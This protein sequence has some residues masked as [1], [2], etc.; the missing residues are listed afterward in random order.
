M[1]RPLLVA[2]V[3]FAPPCA[4]AWSDIGHGVI[5]TIAYRHLNARAKSRVDVLLCVG[6][7]ARYRNIVMASNWAD[8]VRPQRGETGPWHYKDLFFRADGKPTD[9]KPDAENVVWAIEKFKRQ[10]GNNK[11]TQ[12]ERAE[13]LRWLLHFVGDAHQPLHAESRVTDAL[14]NGDRGG[15]DFSI[16]PGNGLPEWNTNLHRVWDSGCGLFAAPMR[17]GEPGADAVIVRIADQIMK[18][19]PMSSLS[20][21]I[22]DLD[23]DNWIRSG[24]EIS[25]S[26]CY[27]TTEGAVPDKKYVLTG[28]RIS[29]GRT[30]LAA[31]RLAAILNQILG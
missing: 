7:D 29:G 15:N 16:V 4:F 14:P 26:F 31:Y 28:Q 17:A 23:A 27:T 5:G 25:K 13:A 22:K 12:A 2:L 21:Q 8:E 9:L 30:A 18:D 19:R 24:F 11:V 20:R 3:L 1:K 10:L 6:V